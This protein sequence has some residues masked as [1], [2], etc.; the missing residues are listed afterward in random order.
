MR[1]RTGVGWPFWTAFAVAL[2]AR[3]ALLD[4]RPLHH[5]E[6]VNGWFLLN[7]LKGEAYRYDPAR[8]HGPFLYY[9]GWLPAR[10]VGMSE[11]AL[12]LPVAIASALLIPLLLPLRRRLGGAGVTAAAW[13]LALSPAAVYYGRDLIHETYLVLFTLGLVASVSL[14]LE[15]HRERDLLLAALTLSLLFTVKETAA[16]TV[17]TL[18]VAALGAAF[19][20]GSLRFGLG[21][22]RDEIGAGTLLRAGLALAL[23]YVLLFTAFF[24]HPSGFV[25]SFRAYLP[26]LEKGIEGTGHEKPWH[27]FPLLLARFELPS[28]AGAAL[29]S[30]IAVRRRDAFGVF[31]AL[32]WLGQVAAYSLIPY[33]TPWLALNMILP[34]SLTAGVL[35]RDLAD[36]NRSGQPLSGGA[37]TALAAL[38]LAALGWSAARVID[39]SLLRYDDERLGLVYVQT[40]R[41]LLG[42]LDLVREAE[43]RSPAE[44]SVKVFASQRWPLPW[45][46]RDYPGVRYADEIPGEPDGDVLILDPAQEAEVKGRLRQRYERREFVLR[47]R[48][49]LVVYIREAAVE[50]ET[51]VET[52]AGEIHVF[53][54]ASLTEALTEIAA[55]YEK[56]SGAQI[57]LNFGASS[58]LARQIREGA[59]ADLFLS[60]DEEKM[61][62]LAREGL[63]LAGT[64]RSVLSNT[65]VVVVPAG[66]RLKISG[67]ADLAAPS[68]QALALA[69]TRTVPAGIYARRLL[70]AR[71]IWPR[72]AGRV[73]PTESV[74]AALAAVASGNADAGIVYRTDAGI[75]KEVRVGF[76]VPRA[77][78]PPISYPFA[79][80]AASRQPEAARG[81]L[82][83]LASPAALEVFRRHGFLVL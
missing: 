79:A 37:R 55:A 76:E 64:R 44:L 39:T 21:S 75:S 5:D 20:A 8:F 45:Y 17:A 73:V 1:N 61:D 65:L 30:W 77:A 69:E 60:A 50:G 66:S 58:T 3:L 35:F 16:L 36:R 31:C 78:G 28:M 83:Y 41:D 43:E 12:R 57:V 51:A 68:V 13:L 27:Y 48:I 25:D 54:A 72:L 71:G 42:L 33:K 9:A 63:L 70:E 67:I 22:L 18:A 34:A 10:L 47:P 53:A 23:P 46:F 14:W 82:A 26:W 38:C 56:A 24:V 81:L 4:V 15:R 2:L 32:W 59:P 7:L 62:A 49:R 29:G 11:T 52:S 40:D 6:G 80:L 19:W 74:R